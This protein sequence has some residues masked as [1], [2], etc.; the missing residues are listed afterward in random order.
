MLMSLD[1]LLTIIEAEY[2]LAFKFEL[3]R[4]NFINCILKLGQNYELLTKGDQE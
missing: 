3:F 2:N 1:Q 4:Y